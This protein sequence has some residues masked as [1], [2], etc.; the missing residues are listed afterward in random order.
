MAVANRLAP[1][2]SASKTP[3]SQKNNKTFTDYISGETVKKKI[4]DMVGEKNSQRFI[5]AIVSAVSNNRNLATCT[6]GTII[7]GALL[8]ES[9]KLTPSPQLGQYYLVPYKIKRKDANGK[10]YWEDAAQFQLGYKGYIQLAIRS[11]YYRDLDVLEVREGEYLG[12]NRLTG[13]HQF[14]FI[15]NEEERNSKP[16]VGYLAYFE[17]TNGFTKTIYW[18]KSDMEKH[19]ITYSKAYA[20]D[21][22]NKTSY[23]FWSTKFNDMAFK[24]M[25]RQLLSRWGIMSIEMQIAYERDMAVI[26]D[27]ENYEYVDANDNA[28][29]LNAIPEETPQL[30]QNQTTNAIDQFF[31]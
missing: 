10:E 3:A 25:I 5:T 12:R 28:N 14:S 20:S 22:E 31:N 18:T 1:A 26:E 24:T 8:G 9:L 30:Q 15:S 4:V 7:A 6:S 2:P 13:K 21:L 23:S 29:I 17:Y 27:N 19:A 16:V 11:N